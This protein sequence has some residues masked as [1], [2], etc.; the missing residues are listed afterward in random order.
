[1]IKIYV[2][3]KDNVIFQTSPK[4][5]GPEGLEVVELDFETVPTYEQIEAKFY[6]VK[7]E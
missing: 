3:H 6:E 1:M 7:E 5:N 4:Q 2:Y